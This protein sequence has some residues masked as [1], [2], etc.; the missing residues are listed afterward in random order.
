LLKEVLFKLLGVVDPHPWTPN[1]TMFILRALLGGSNA[2]PVHFGEY[3]TA[4]LHTMRNDFL[5]VVLQAYDVGVDAR[6]RAD[7]STESYELLAPIIIDGEDA[8]GDPA[9]TQRAIV[10]NPH[11]ADIAKGTP[12]EQAFQDL[13]GVPL[14]DFAGRYIQRTLAETP[15]SVGQRFLR[16]LERTMREYPGVLPD[17]VRRNISVVLVG[18]EIFNEHVSYYG[19]SPVDPTGVFQVMIEDTLGLF[20]TGAPRVAVDDFV[21]E[22]VNA[23]AYN[24]QRPHFLTC[25][26]AA[27]NILWLHLS[28]AHRWW[29]RE[30]RSRG[31]ATL[32]VPA[33]RAQMRERYE[34]VIQEQVVNTGTYG[35]LPCFGIRVANAHDYG[36][37]IPDRLDTQQFIVNGAII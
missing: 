11:P 30:R 37:S 1:T 17:R 27:A 25:Y 8:V 28:S 16:A 26:D 7:L 32:E 6:G 22:V 13:R 5:R 15:D 10:L 4:T 34:Y 14:G 19:G 2:I 36:L 3:R 18:L 24:G 21:E 33:L 23:L 31:R 35:R 9:F 20:P 12:Q 29:E